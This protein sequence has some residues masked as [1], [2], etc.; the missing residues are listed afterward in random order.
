MVV[1][2]SLSTFSIL[3]EVNFIKALKANQTQDSLSHYGPHLF[4]NS[5]FWLNDV[6]T[7]SRHWELTR[8]K[9]INLKR[10]IDKIRIKIWQS[11]IKNLSD[12][13]KDVYIISLWK[14]YIVHAIIIWTLFSEC[15]I[16]TTGKS[17]FSTVFYKNYLRFSS[18][19]VAYPP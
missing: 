11:T 13:F 3:S 12:T 5:Q 1:T 18:A 17:Q 2:I 16:K 14:S 8:L 19:L 9:I 7:L 15:Y 4:L 10:L 6:N